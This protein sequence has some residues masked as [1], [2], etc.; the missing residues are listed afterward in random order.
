MGFKGLHGDT[1][2]VDSV[3]EVK[4]GH[5]EPSCLLQASVGFVVLSF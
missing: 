5:R 3:G 2:E 1:M 4:R